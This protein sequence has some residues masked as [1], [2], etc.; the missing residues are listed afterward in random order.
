MAIR[1]SDLS[2]SILKYYAYQLTTGSGFYIPIM[3]LYLLFRGLSY[4]QITVISSV[5]AAVIVVS[6]IPTGFVGDR[7][8]RRNSMI[9]SASLYAVVF[10]GLAFAEDFATLLGLGALLGIAGTFQS[11]SMDAWLYDILSENDRGDE[12]TRIRGRG[13]SMRKWMVAATM[14]FGGFLYLWHPRYPFVAAAALASIGVP[15]LLTLPKNIQY[16]DEEDEENITVIDAIPVITSQLN[17]RH[18]RT[19]VLF[20]GLFMA[21]PVTVSEF[22]QPITVNTVHLSGGVPFFEGTELQEEAGLGVL[23]AA[24]NFVA[25][26]ASDRAAAV[27]E[28]LGFRRTVLFVPLL[29]ALLLVTPLVV[30]LLAIPVFFAIKSSK[31]MMIPIINNHINDQIE[32]FGR[33]TVLSCVSVV[34]SLIQIPFLLMSGVVA[35]MIEPVVAIGAVSGIFIVAGSLLWLAE[36]PVES[37]D[38]AAR[39]VAGD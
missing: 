35:D 14:I 4:T 17:R 2:L 23:Y 22:I 29:T 1:R 39:P 20:A 30:P 13:Q 18:L 28:L 16:R 6:E 26:I 8:G 15:I 32:S 21:V 33:A 31:V 19:F 27:E 37:T 38:V 34:F 9:V 11:G 36:S 7:I 24:F 25:A 12:F 3:T 5:T 10:A